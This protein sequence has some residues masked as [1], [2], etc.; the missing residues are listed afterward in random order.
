MAQKLDP[1]KDGLARFLN[2]FHAN[3]G[4]FTMVCQCLPYFWFTMISFSRVWQVLDLVAE[5]LANV[6]TLKV[7]RWS[8]WQVLQVSKFAGS[9]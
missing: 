4:V 8:D 6:T 3:L 9:M 2:Q 1:E 7:W 5:A